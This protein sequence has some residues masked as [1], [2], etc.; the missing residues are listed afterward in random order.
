[1]ILWRDVKATYIALFTTSSATVR[2]S[3]STGAAAFPAVL[4]PERGMCTFFRR[5]RRLGERLDEGNGVA[6][7]PRPGG[8]LI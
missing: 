7:V 1:M 8:A 4:V 6:G 3:Y 5:S 2:S